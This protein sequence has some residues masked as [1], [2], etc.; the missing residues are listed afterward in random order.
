MTWG[1]LLDTYLLMAWVMSIVV[2][3]TLQKKGHQFGCAV[4]PLVVLFAFGWPI[5][6]PVVALVMRCREVQPPAR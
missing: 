1:Q 6:L 3:V 2:A 5:I 4:V